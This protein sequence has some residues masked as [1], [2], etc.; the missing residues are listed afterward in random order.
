MVDVLQLAKT[1]KTYKSLLMSLGDQKIRILSFIGGFAKGGYIKLIQDD[2]MI[3][4]IGNTKKSLLVIIPLG[5]FV[6][7]CI[8]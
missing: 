8:Y 5:S 4:D 7:Y 1:N 3:F 6:G 2:Y